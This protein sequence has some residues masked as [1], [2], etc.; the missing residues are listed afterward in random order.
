[1]RRA[2]M[3][4]PVTLQICTVRKAVCPGGM[5]P[6]WLTDADTTPLTSGDFLRTPSY[7]VDDAEYI[8]ETSI[9]LQSALA[10]AG[11]HGRNGTQWCSW[12]K[13][14]TGRSLGSRWRPDWQYNTAPSLVEQAPMGALDCQLRVGDA[15]ADGSHC[16]AVV[17]VLCARLCVFSWPR[18]TWGASAGLP[19][20]GSPGFPY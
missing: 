14:E 18:L 6:A 4:S 2:A 7:A 8:D 3:R 5:N 17:L 19:D 16:R 10:G 1:M 13:A 12:D 15:Q 20:G 11:N 9:R